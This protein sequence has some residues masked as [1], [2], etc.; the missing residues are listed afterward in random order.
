MRRALYLPLATLLACA[1]AATL[2]SELPVENIPA[3]RVILPPEFEA[4]IED[5]TRSTTGR[6]GPNYWQNEAEYDLRVHV[7]PDSL[8][9]RG[10]STIRYHNRSPD[11]LGVLV[12]DV[13]QQFH[14]PG[15]ARVDPAEVT[16]GMELTRLAVNGQSFREGNI[17][18]GGGV[19]MM[20]G[21]KL[22]IRPTQPIAAGTTT[23]LEINWSFPIPARGVGERMGHNAGNLIFLAYFYPQFAVYDDVVGWDADQFLGWGEFYDGFGSYNVTIEAPAQWLVMGTGSLTNAG[24][25]LAPE[26]ARRLAIAETSDTVVHVV[27]TADLGRVTSGATGW[28]QW[29]FRA[30]S[31]RDVAFSLSRESLWDAMR[32]PTGAR[33][34]NGSPAFTRV[35]AIYR[36]GT[37]SWN[38][39]ADYTRH[40]VSFLSDYTGIPYP[41]SHMTIVE[42]VGILG[43]GMEYPMMSLINQPGEVYLYDTTAH[44]I[45][46]MWVPMIVSTDERRYGWLD[47]GITT[48]HEQEAHRDRFP[49]T[50]PEAN[51]LGGYLAAA[52]AGAEGEIMRRTDYHYSINEFVTASYDKPGT[53]L[54]TLHGLLGEEVFLKAY[55]EFLNRWKWKQAYPW[56]LWNTFEDVSGQDLGW[57]WTSW[58][59][60][61]G[62][63]DQA[64]ESVTTGADGSSRIVI[65]SLGQNPMPTQLTIDLADGS[66][67]E[68]TIPVERWFGGIERNTVT[69]PGRV[70]RVRIDAAELFPDINR[71]NNVWGN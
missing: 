49:G 62:V 47:E 31:V 13:E 7:D 32:A 6:P 9:V 2:R 70:T 46:H 8:L 48:Y 69:V 25:M 71:E 23:T 57:F 27:T 4:A 36:A 12:L 40:A 29:S 11:R 52:R 24:E 5:G 34:S 45:A 14:L 10:A 38:R 66:V 41:W 17:G 44:E 26:I 42:G 56:D 33:N 22:V 28:R 39:V 3:P 18:A 1:P 30:D 63:L 68:R 61:T 37:D 51:F 43:G 19:W 15:A 58:Y 60:T 67:V 50:H 21:T 55:R 20:D 54:N 16:T 65:R 35:D 53:L 59:E 64:V